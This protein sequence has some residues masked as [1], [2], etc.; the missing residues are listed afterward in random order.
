RSG[1][2]QA[3]NYGHEDWWIVRYDPSGT[4]AWEAAMG[5][6]GQDRPYSIALAKEGA[7]VIAGFSAS[8]PSGNKYPA[9]RGGQDIWV[10]KVDRFGRMIWQQTYG[11]SGIE[12]SNTIL[13][14]P[15]GGWVIAGTDSPG[16]WMFELA[17]EQIPSP[18]A[19]VWLW[20]IDEYAPERV[21]SIAGPQG[22]SFCLETVRKLVNIGRRI[23]YG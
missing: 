16:V 22:S 18:I 13:P 11:D 6:Q 19:G 1:D 2:K 23:G 12:S 3:D 14:T 4:L 8:G 21:L 15:E 9:S 5:G 7:V 10:A 20:Q 17:P